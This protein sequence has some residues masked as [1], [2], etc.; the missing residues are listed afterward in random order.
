[1][2]ASLRTKLTVLYGGLFAAIL[3]LISLAVF[4]AIASNAE[5]N[6]KQ[7]LT[8]SGVV[9][10]RVWALRTAQ[11][12]NGAGLLSRDF[13]FRE[14]IATND[15]ATIRS[16][17]DNL[18]A[19]L[20]M[21]MAMLIGVDGRITTAANAPVGKLSPQALSV[22][23]NDESVSGVVFIGATPYEV[24]SVPVMAPV[25]MGWLVFA[26]KLD[27]AQMRSMQALAALPLEAS[28]LRRTADGRWPRR[29]GGFVAAALKGADRSAHTLTGSEGA[30]LALVKPL[31]SID[32]GEKVVLLLQYPIAKAMAPYRP[33]LAILVG[34]AVLGLGALLTGT[35]ALARGVTRPISAL[36]RAARRMQAGEQ[37]RVEVA[38]RDEIGALAQSFNAMVE[39]IGQRDN[40]RARAAAILERARDEAEAANRAKS[41]FLANMSHEVR[42]PL[43][44]VLGIAGVLAGSPL[45]AR[46][47][48]MVGIIQSS[49][50][51]LQRVLN[52]VL[53]L[54]RVEAGRLEIVEDVFDL[55]ETV[56]G[57]AISTELQCKA[58]GLVFTLVGVDAEGFVL[59]DRARLEQ[60]LGNLLGNALKFTAA[61]EIG[62]VVTRL[63]PMGGA[64]RFEISDTGIGFD[65]ALAESLFQPFQQADGSNT[66]QFSGSGLGLSI[67]R[68]LARAMGGDLTAVATPGEGATFTL[69]LTLP[70]A[71]KSPPVGPE[72]APQTQAP[73]PG[74]G[75]AAPIRVLLADDHE[76]NRTVV[77]LI[78][79]AVGVELTSVENGA[80][81]V[82]AFET[83]AFDVVLMDIQMPVMD[84]LTAIGLMRRREAERGP[85]RTPILVLSAN[86]LPE[87]VEAAVAAGADGHVAKPITPPVLLGAIEDALNAADKTESRQVA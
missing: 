12:E 30:A 65:P 32:P 24:V 28:I 52:D 21:D 22:I 23:E 70:A 81:A 14:A 76:T 72:P 66:R 17:L 55:G 60:I 51:D 77:R 73:R 71:A 34:L 53:D 43:N 3:L 36:E 49:A 56:R 78:L 16:A 82:E 84:G 80:Q 41:S 68:Q 37:A 67:S 87:H 1:M 42:T 79:G 13:G 26:A 9:F 59:G 35:W 38:T 63:D 10:D 61:G 75:A 20:G 47:R 39:E 11:L 48:E 29:Y 50:F 27:Q 6:V 74:G 45:D 15:A 2:F 54:A 57:L 44:G 18:E 62:L 86:A 69:A 46:Q 64:F 7:E 83:G 4:A 33:L 40:E 85:K 8:T 58:K 5:R 31:R 19:R 25:T